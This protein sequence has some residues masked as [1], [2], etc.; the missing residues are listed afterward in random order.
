MFQLCVNAREIWRF[1]DSRGS[2]FSGAV[3]FSWLCWIFVATEG[4]LSSCGKQ[5]SH[6]HDFFC[7]GAQ[8][9]G[10]WAQ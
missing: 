6:W 8:V 9:L 1:V 5:V 10:M 2:I 4:A 3:F 7:C